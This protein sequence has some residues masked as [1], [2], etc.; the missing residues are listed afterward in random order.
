MKIQIHDF[1]PIHHFECDLD[2]DLHLIVGE[3]NVGKSYGI[4][5]VYLLLKTLME[6]RKDLDSTEFLHER[7]A[8]LPEELFDKVSALNMG[9]E[10]D[11]GDIF[12]DEIIGLLINTFLKRFRDYI[13]E[14]Y[15]PID[16]VTNK[17]SGK[18]PRIRLTF[19]SA[20]ID[21][22]VAEAGKILEV[23]ELT[24]GS[25]IVLRCVAESRPPDYEADNIV[26]YHDGRD[27]GRFKASFIVA[28]AYFFGNMLKDALGGIRDIHYL[29]ASRSAAYQV[30]SASRGLIAALSENQSSSN[31]RLLLKSPADLSTI[32]T[33]LNDYFRDLS[34]IKQDK[35]SQGNGPIH[36][37]AKDI[38]RDILGGNV[39]FDGETKQ[40]SYTP[41][42]T[43]LRLDVDCASSMVSEL[44]PL[45]AFLRYIVAGPRATTRAG[46]PDIRKGYS[47]PKTLVFME[48]PEAHLHPANQARLMSAFAA[49]IFAA[50]VKI[51]LTS[52]SNY[53]F[54][55]LNNLILAGEIDMD[56]VAAYVFKPSKMG[57]EA[58]PLVVDRLGIDDENFVDVAEELYEEKLDLIE[59]VNADAG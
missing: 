47:S 28:C 56:A 4:K 33:P 19:G 20:E 3:N 22:G 44:S 54:T 46:S 26:I 21:I 37:I 8:Q 7:V 53:L 10:A 49:L 43:G 23:K 16:H 30:L 55:K 27:Y 42:G 38:E 11:I 58:L 59:R 52:H 2:K 1:G 32:S 6:S 18:S 50:D 13:G 41:R 34:E 12:R 40:M 57:S 51:F 14:T 48:E 29:P 31:D 9:D 17:F 5:V 15:G 45:V 25:G 35:N 39:E 24:I 36:G